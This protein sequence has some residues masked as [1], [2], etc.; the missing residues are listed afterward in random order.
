MKFS[1]RDLLVWG[2]GAAAGLVVTPVPWKLLDDTAKW[3]QN[4]GWI[5]QPARGPVEVKQ[6]ACTLCPNGCG[7]RVRMAAG[8]PVG[9]AGV[10]THPVTH[11]ALC[12]LAFGA[13]QLNWH[14]E[15]LKAVR[16][17]GSAS[18]WEDARAA[19]AKARNSGRVVVIDGY[20]GRAASQVLAA[21]AEKR[22]EYRV[23]RGS[24]TQA[25]ASY[26]RWGGVPGSAL[27]YDL[28]NARTVVSFGA[29]VL[30]GWG[31]PGR[32]T[33][34]WAEKAA[35]QSDPQLRIF[36]IE[37][38]LSRTASRAYQWIITRPGLESALA[39]GIARVLLEEKLVAARGPMPELTLADAASQTALSGDT[40]RDL[41]RTIAAQAPVVAIG[42]D[43]N[44]AIAALNVVLGAVGTRGGI[45]RRSSSTTAQ[46]SAD[47]AIGSARVVVLDSS[48]PWNFEPATDAE[49]FRFAA[50]NGGPTKSDWLLPAPGF[51]EES[52]DVPSAPTAGAETYAIA[53]ALTK[54][55]H[56]TQ[57]CAE[58]LASFDSSLDS[59]DKIIHARCAE[60]FRTRGGTIQ[61]HN[62]VSVAKIESAQKLEGQLSSGAVWVGE[63]ASGGNIRC[64]LQ[65]WPAADAGSLELSGSWSAPVMPT[66][67]TKLY[68]E[69]GLRESGRNA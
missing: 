35:G 53:V 54:A 43:E 64:A 3:S 66:L 46:L 9:V 62:A 42:R 1:R 28:E 31:V 22:G 47:A 21:L 2:A 36:Q 38:S 4:W 32:F 24:E 13:H 16:H 18:S 20:P 61:S 17:R 26:E 55:M 44:P 23:V 52:T 67:A 6:S 14:P 34:L 59:A 7:L 58:F 27:G 19:F 15:R 37:P 45:V 25:L 33:R 40:I 60:L 49:V 50:W 39:A 57:S 12:P 11:G 10:A 41:A 30:D 56:K 68:Q 8:W 69:S 65:Q 48:V 63:P 29:P 51:L 5:P